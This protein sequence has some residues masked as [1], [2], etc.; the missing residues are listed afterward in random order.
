MRRIEKQH[1]SVGA[2]VPR[3]CDITWTGAVKAVRRGDVDLI[4]L[5]R[6]ADAFYKKINTA[7]MTIRRAQLARCGW[8]LPAIWPR[9]DAAS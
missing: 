9:F 4:G 5:G 6:W 3:M 7:D 2:E 8:S 1:I